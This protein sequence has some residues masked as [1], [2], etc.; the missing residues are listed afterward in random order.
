[1]PGT[2]AQRPP[3]TSGPAV[4]AT[5]H[6]SVVLAAG[7]HDSPQAT[8]ALESLCRAYWYP[9]YAWLRRRGHTTHDAQDLVQSFLASLLQRRSFSTAAQDKGRFRSFLLAALN[10]FLADEWDKAR[11]LKRGGGQTLLSLDEAQADARYRAEPTASASPDQLFDKRWA[12]TLLEQALARLREEHS[13]SPRQ[14][15]LLQ[16]F[17]T[18]VP[19]GGASQRVAAELG[20]SPGAA[21]VAVHRLRQRYRE[22]VRAEVANTVGALAEVEDELGYLLQA[23]RN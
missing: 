18:D 12:L 7:A 13:A 20:L 11:A 9:L 3:S 17:L 23:I 15:E 8:A 4:F 10:H 21:R 19:D 14:F 6:W 2:D 5:T 1:M 22:L 16:P